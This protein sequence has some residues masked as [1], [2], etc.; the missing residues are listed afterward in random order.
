VALRTL[1]DLGDVAG[2]RVFVRVD[3]NVPLRDGVVADDSRIRATLPTLLELLDRGARLV[4]ASHLGRP[5][6]QVREDLRLAP[7][8]A[9]LASQMGKPCTSLSEV[10]PASLPDDDVVLLENLRFDP[11]EEANDVSFAGRLAELADAYVDDAFGAVHRAHASV[12]ALPDL[13]HASGRAAVAGRLLQKEVSI[14]GRLLEDA[15]APY[16]AILGGAKVSDKL[17]VI[18]SLAERVD[19]LV[20]GG[21]MAFT[22]LVAEGAQVGDSLVE[23]GQVDRVRAALATAR[24][25][26]V[27]VHLP[28][29][30]V[31]AAA[32]EAEAPTQV[33]RA[34]AIPAGLR[35][36]DIGP[37]SVATFTEVI[38]TAR[39]IL[40]NGPMGVFELP[41]FEAGTRAIAQACAKADAFTVVG[42][43]DS[44][45]AIAQ[46]GLG[47]SFDHLSTGGGASLEFL[48]GRALPGITILEGRG[49]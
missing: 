24:E 26:G 37:A 6:G 36:L 49:P 29:D 44:L 45:A 7:V 3:L 43:G 38:G 17:A 11:G 35:G 41:P 16:V 28:T 33:V 19:A 39:T 2:S 13:M 30:I 25:R 8:G 27:T 47:G 22:L 31:A 46:A 4:L 10:T 48:E 5:K 21:A 34:D 14:L 40:W 18:G 32:A 20:I 1:D 12:R 15:D 42:G 23:L 9:A